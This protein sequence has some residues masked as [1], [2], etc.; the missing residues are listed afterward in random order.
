MQL[1]GFSLS[2]LLMASSDSSSCEG[3]QASSAGSFLMN[4]VVDSNPKVS[5][6][7]ARLAAAPSGLR[8]LSSAPR[9]RKARICSGRRVQTR[10][11]GTMT[12]HNMLM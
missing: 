8:A 5:S 3:G 2:A 4:M 11:R 9:S 10:I 12:K 7:C 6:Q 1:L